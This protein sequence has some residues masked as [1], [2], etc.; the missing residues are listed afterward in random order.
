MW[1]L[2]TRDKERRMFRFIAFSVW[3]K[4]HVHPEK[5]QM[6]N[7]AAVVFFL[8]RMEGSLT[9]PVPLSVMETNPGAHL[10][11]FTV[12]NGLIVVRKH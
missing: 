11:L 10:M 9:A 8:S 2:S 7:K 6:I 12:D 3:Q 1:Q 4:L 5:R